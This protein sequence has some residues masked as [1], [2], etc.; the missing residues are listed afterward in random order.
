VN[1]AVRDRR[2]LFA[3]RSPPAHGRFGG[4]DTAGRLQA[5]SAYDGAMH[6][7]DLA[8]ATEPGTRYKV[9][10]V[11]VPDRLGTRVSVDRYGEAFALA[12]NDFNDSEFTGPTFSQ[13]NRILFA[14][15]QD[16]GLVFAITG[17][18]GR[19]KHH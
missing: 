4:G 19:G 17:P 9:R 12:R 2:L 10:W 14:N 8:M 16:P 3:C 5:M 7:P 15:I 1:P 18:W 6:I 13:D 11:D